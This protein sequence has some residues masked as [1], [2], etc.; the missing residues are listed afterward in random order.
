MENHTECV[1]K[2]GKLGVEFWEVHAFKTGRSN[3][4]ENIGRS[5]AVIGKPRE[6]DVTQAPEV[7]I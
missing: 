6:Y 7:N 4:K 2:K 1:Y 3:C 5:A